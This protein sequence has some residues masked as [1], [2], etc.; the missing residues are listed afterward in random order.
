M[1]TTI[2]TNAQ[3]ISPVTYEKINPKDGPEYTIK[4]LKEKIRV[5]HKLSGNRVYGKN[6]P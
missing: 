2:S 3:T 4:R 5:C 6:L 1:S